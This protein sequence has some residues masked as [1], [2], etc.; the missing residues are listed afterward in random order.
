MSAGALLARGA[1]KIKVVRYRR[2]LLCVSIAKTPLRPRTR[3]GVTGD[4]LLTYPPF[5][6]PFSTVS[7]SGCNSAD[8]LSTST[9]LPRYLGPCSCFPFTHS[10]PLP[11][12]SLERSGM[13]YH[14]IKKHNVLCLC[15]RRDIIHYR[16][17][18]T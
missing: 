15:P 5:S 16:A 12:L 1:G 2:H 4:L 11:F 17:L 13:V 10:P 18:V 8:Y 9:W 14:R 3:T 6:Q 7:I